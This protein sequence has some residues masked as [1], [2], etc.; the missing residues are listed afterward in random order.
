MKS[1]INN[2][3]VLENTR[4][5]RGGSFWSPGFQMSRHWT[6]AAWYP[7][8]N[9]R[10]PR[11][12]SFA[13][14]WTNRKRTG[15]KGKLFHAIFNS[16]IYIRLRLIPVSPFLFFLNF[17]F[18][19]SLVCHLCSI[20]VESNVL[21]LQWD[22][23]I[24]GIS[25]TENKTICRNIKYVWKVTNCFPLNTLWARYVLLL[26]SPSGQVCFCWRVRYEKR[27]YINVK[28]TF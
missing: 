25:K 13:T 7:F 24:T 2:C 18:I 5:T 15:L 28:G 22:R 12:P 4:N 20:F 6:A 10:T 27:C 23:I 26:T 19:S 9:V 3:R 11:G 16:F 21:M 17:H 1:E 8:R 14:T